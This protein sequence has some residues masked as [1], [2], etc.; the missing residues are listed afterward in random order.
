MKDWELT[1]KEW[2]GRNWVATATAAQKKLWD[3]LKDFECP[4][5]NTPGFKAL[6]IPVNLFNELEG[7]LK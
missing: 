2:N 6:V 3:H 7:V 5:C 1:T 4:K